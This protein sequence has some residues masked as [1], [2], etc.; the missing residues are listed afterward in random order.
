M[1]TWV[2]SLANLPPRGSRSGAG[3]GWIE[4]DLDTLWLAKVFLGLF[5]KKWLGL[6]NATGV[7]TKFTLFMHFWLS[8]CGRR[9]SYIRSSVGLFP[10]TLAKWGRKRTKLSPIKLGSSESLISSSTVYF[11]LKR[12]SATFALNYSNVI[13]FDR[14]C[15]YWS[16]SHNEIH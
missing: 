14:N 11:M 16:L 8:S 9:R 10:Y 3:V 13:F 6:S 2:R 12:R 4:V 5:K 7:A 15:E 1:L